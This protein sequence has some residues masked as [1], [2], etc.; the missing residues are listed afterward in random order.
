MP[1][2]IFSLE[3]KSNRNKSNASRAP[4]IKGE[5]KLSLEL[6]NE[7]LYVMVCHAKNLAMPDGSKEEPNSYVKV[8]LRPDPVKVTKRKTKVVR[9][10][11]HPSFM[12]MVRE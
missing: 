10:N 9:K 8:Y 12:E 11:C 2:L 4:R 6:R 7:I 1:H 3:Q 5:L